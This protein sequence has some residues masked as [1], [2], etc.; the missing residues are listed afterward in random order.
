VYSGS[1]APRIVFLRSKTNFSSPPFGR[2]AL[3]WE[4]RQIAD[5]RT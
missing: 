2:Q 3:P 4:A 1:P 5:D